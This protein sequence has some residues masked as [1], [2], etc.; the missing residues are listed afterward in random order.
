MAC[1]HFDGHDACEFQVSLFSYGTA[2]QHFIM[3]LKR[4]VG[5]SASSAGGLLLGR[6]FHHTLT[7]LQQRGIAARASHGAPTSA[8]LGTP[9]PGTA[10]SVAAHKASLGGH[11]EDEGADLLSG[12]AGTASAADLLGSLQ[13]KA[14]S[15]PRWHSGSD[16]LGGRA[17]SF[18]ARQEEAVAAPGQ[19]GSMMHALR[20]MR[21]QRQL[22][23]AEAVPP[24][25]RLESATET[26]QAGVPGLASTSAGGLDPEALSAAQA[27]GASLTVAQ[28]KA[29]WAPITAMLAHG[30]APQKEE[31]VRVLAA[32]SRSPA[33]HDS[34]VKARLPVLL[35]DMMGLTHLT[36]QGATPAV[37]APTPPTQ[38]S[39]LQAPH[40]LLAAGGKVYKAGRGLSRVGRALAVAMV[41]NLTRSPVGMAAM[42]DN[43][44][45][46]ALQRLWQEDKAA[47]GSAE[48]A[49]AAAAAVAGAVDPATADLVAHM[50]GSDRPDTASDTGTVGESEGEGEEGGGIT[51][52]VAPPPAPVPRA[53]TTQAGSGQA[54][55]PLGRSKSSP[56]TSLLSGVRSTWSSARAGVRAGVFKAFVMSKVEGVLSAARAVAT[57]APPA[58]TTPLTPAPARDARPV[59]AHRPLQRAVSW[60][61]APRGVAAGQPVATIDGVGAHSPPT[62][63]LVGVD[64]A[65]E[66]QALPP[67]PREPAAL[68]PASTGEAG[69]SDSTSPAAPRGGRQAVLA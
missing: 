45:L 1:F 35:G 4:T 69:L 33:N 62:Q 23:Q 51:L 28:S 31:A 6:L 65:R 41:A 15:L 34:I 19:S 66:L 29:L 59:Q 46:P 47:E 53:A 58:S 26:L 3:E 11:V 37:P 49:A 42:Q 14:R 60:S 16:L 63:G 48:L 18:S 13:S 22:P 7:H 25:A 27:A 20:N 50:T 36:G 64:L 44:I 24:A 68:T 40:A 17:R 67:A 55:P 9:A 21:S 39:T 5:A 38:R 32:L 56:V 57:G 61:V 54:G 8:L 2:P 52:D 30:G 12:L 10:A 43:G